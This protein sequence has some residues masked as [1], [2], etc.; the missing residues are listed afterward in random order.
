MSLKI[1]IFLGPPGSGKGTQASLIAKRKPG[2]VHVSS[3]NI[4]R[5]QILKKTPIGIAIE[6]RMNSGELVDDETILNCAFDS[7]MTLRQQESPP[8]DILLDGIPRNTFQGESLQ[9]W[10]S[11]Q[12]GISLG[13]IIYFQAGRNEIIHRFSD[14]RI[15]QTCQK[16]FDL[17]SLNKQKDDCNTCHGEGPYY[18]RE[19]DKPD[20]VGHR[21]DIFQELTY[22]LVKFYKKENQVHILSALLP[23]EEIYDKVSNLLQDN[24]SDPSALVGDV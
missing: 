9:K 22:P 19:D 11:S 3:G 21:F 20:I 24:Q 12:P 2:F 23:I 13:K 14:R 5:S 8:S 1:H 4:L 15:C 17:K 10:V 16:S 7:F 18:Q 6:S